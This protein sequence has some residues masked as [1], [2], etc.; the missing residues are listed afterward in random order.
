MTRS[1]CKTSLPI[2]CSTLS[3]PMLSRNKEVHTGSNHTRVWS[4][5]HA[6]RREPAAIKGR[7]STRTI[8]SQ[9]CRQVVCGVSLSTTAAP[10][11]PRSSSAPPAKGAE[12]SNPFL[13]L[14]TEDQGDPSEM[15]RPTGS[16]AILFCCIC[17][18]A[19]SSSM[20]V[21]GSAAP[22]ETPKFISS[23]VAHRGNLTHFEPRA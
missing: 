18:V 4:A 5:R 21:V 6:Y 12:K 3:R 1:C 22:E 20:A 15:G 19:L 2:I 8:S 23:T 10:I 14:V 7:S 11:S 16:A 17:V 13:R 9:I